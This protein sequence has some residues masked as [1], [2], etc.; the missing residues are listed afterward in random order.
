MHGCGLKVI[1]SSCVLPRPK[2]RETYLDLTQQLR[3]CL[4][5]GQLGRDRPLTSSL[6]P[7]ILRDNSQQ[8][9]TQDS[10]VPTLD[11]EPNNLI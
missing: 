7:P 4:V 11:P 9:T 1:P 10:T 8:G 5:V 6:V 2:I 3:V